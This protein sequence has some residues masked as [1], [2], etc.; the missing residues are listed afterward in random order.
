MILSITNGLLFIVGFFIFVFQF[1]NRSICLNYSDKVMIFVLYLG[2]IFG[3]FVL[4][5]LRKKS[6][7]KKE[8]IN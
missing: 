8:N 2:A 1:Y 4:N 7:K 6:N 5:R 3:D